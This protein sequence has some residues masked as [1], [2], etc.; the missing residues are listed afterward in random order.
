MTVSDN[1]TVFHLSPD[2][3]P[4][5]GERVLATHGAFTVT[6]FRYPSSV[7]GLRIENARGQVTVLPYLGQM[8]WDAV[9][10]G[11][12][13]TMGN[14]FPYPRRGA[15]ILE[16]YGAF[17]YHAGVLR[18]GTPGPQDDHP[19]HGE[20]PVAAMDSAQLRCGHDQHGAFVE[21]GGHAEYVMGFGPHY[22]ARPRVRLHA[23]SGLIDVEMAVKNLSAHPME[24][25]YMLHANF[26]FIAGAQIHQPTDFSPDS[27]VVR[28]TIPGHVKPSPDFTALLE[29]L[30]VNPARMQKLDEPDR[31][32]P[33]Q[34]FYIRGLGR[35]ERG[36][37]RLVM[38]LP[39]GDCF[40]VSYDPAD[41][42][43]CVRWILNDGDAQVAAFALPST[44]E[45]EG[46]TAEKAKGHVR[47]L[48]PGET[49]NFPVTVG[50]LS[51]QE[52]PAAISD[53]NDMSKD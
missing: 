24:L 29:D 4:A 18:N 5:H 22:S 46:Y 48:A 51:A 28:K 34:V 25:M 41:L 53:I 16:T 10:D 11:R 39:D 26:D 13:L 42:P 33:E 38:E 7:E 32:S 30:A 49:V 52:T 3:F 40:S 19:L 8:I 35:D 21:V 2:L 1:D 43:H 20:M 50:Y 36:R 6:A 15:S 45:P 12:R 44:C 17:A 23:E 47:M 27:T 9:F 37:T 14:M 31:Y